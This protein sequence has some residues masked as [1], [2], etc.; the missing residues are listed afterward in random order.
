[1]RICGK[2]FPRSASVASVQRVLADSVA[3]NG[4]SGECAPE[5][6]EISGGLPSARDLKAWMPSVLDVLE[7]RG[8]DVRELSEVMRSP[9]SEID[10]RWDH[11][12]ASDRE[13]WSVLLRCGKRGL[14]ADVMMSFLASVRDGRQGLRAFQHL[15][16]RVLLFGCS[17]GVV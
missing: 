16:R 9:R 11:G 7:R 12:G 1:M 14:P 3:S 15:F 17:A 13:L 2:M 4:R 5:F 8:L 6:P 10:P